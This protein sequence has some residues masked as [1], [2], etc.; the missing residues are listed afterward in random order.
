MSVVC[1]KVYHDHITIAADSCVAAG[2]FVLPFHGIQKLF[3]ANGMIIGT[4]GMVEEISVMHSFLSEIHDDMPDEAT[5]YSISC[6]IRE[7]YAYYKERRGEMDELQRP[8]EC[9]TNSF[10]IVYK[11]KLFYCKG[12]EVF[13][14]D[15]YAAIGSGEQ[16]ATTAMFLGQDPEEA[17]KTASALNVFV[18]LPVVSFTAERG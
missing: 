14:I 18:R 6:F 9:D 13:E 8:E 10:L 5:T 1:A 11:G 4:V 7:F 3:S 16:S 12:L 2:D 17:V 15:D